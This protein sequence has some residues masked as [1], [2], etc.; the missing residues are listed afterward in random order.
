MRRKISLY[1]GGQLVDL[2]DDSLVLFNYTQDD[3]DNPTVVKN[4]YS[5][6][7]TIPGTADNNSK[8]FGDIFRLDRFNQTTVTGHG[9]GFNASK[10]TPFIIFNELN[11]VLES[12]YAKL[13]GITRKKGVVQYKVSLFGGLGS[14]LSR[15]SSKAD[16]SKMTLADLDYLGTNDPESEFDYA[17]TRTLVSSAWQTLS[18]QG[19]D[20]FSIINFAPAYDGIPEDFDADRLAFDGTLYAR[21]G[22]LIANLSRDYTGREAHDLRSY[23]QRPVIR[24]KAILEA[25]ANPDNNGGYTVDYSQ[26][27]SDSNP[28]W[29]D[30][31]MTL[32]ILNRGKRSGDTFTKKDLLGATDTPAKFLIS[33]CRMFGYKILVD[34]NAKTVSIMSRREFFSGN[35]VDLTDRVDISKEIPISPL[36]ME[37]RWYKMASPNEGELAAAYNKAYGR[38]YGAQRIDTGYEFSEEEKDITDGIIFKGAV[39]ATENSDAFLD[40]WRETYQA[41]EPVPMPAPFLGGGTYEIVNPTTGETTEFPLVSGRITYTWWNS[42]DNG[43]DIVDLPQLHKEDNGAID[44]GGV[45]LFFTG[46]VE[47]EHLHLSD[48]LPAMGETPCWNCSSTNIR[49]LFEIPHFSR[50]RL[51]SQG[52]ITD[53]LDWGESAELYIDAEYNDANVGIYPDFWRSYLT[54]RMD[55]DTMIVRLKVNLA[56]MVVGHNLLRDFYW[57]DGSIWSLNRIINHSLTTWDDTECEFIRVMDTGNYI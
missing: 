1:I 3:L 49:Q 40:A 14:F 44:G 31:W 13:D 6:Q 8:L 21:T 9:A 29:D 47:Q 27:V 25:I 16:G 33:Y 53:S 10:K 39:Q 50:F 48:D 18:E 46:M 55:D 7:I 38:E 35:V 42:T 26:D 30:L 5:Q 17:I 36:F 32:P 37:S 54:D 15:L 24:V 51:N 20:L 52:K 28:Y 57:F 23:L 2:D 43:K 11:E 56:G 12:G 22:T 4:S 45:L 34:D 41:Q 19:E